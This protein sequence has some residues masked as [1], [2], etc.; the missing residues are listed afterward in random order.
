M[1]V[2]GIGGF[3]V[4]ESVSDDEKETDG[5][6]CFRFDASDAIGIFVLGRMAS[7]MMLLLQLFSNSLSTRKCGSFAMEI[8]ETLVRAFIF[9]AV[10]R[11]LTR[12]LTNLSPH[13]SPRR[14]FVFV[15]QA[16]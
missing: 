13:T 9:A 5:G 12:F 7:V 15:S 1:F 2:V 8:K 11:P 4:E 14:H 16:T 6:M 3:T 10:L